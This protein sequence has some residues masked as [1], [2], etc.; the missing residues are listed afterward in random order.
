MPV[1]AGSWE[2]LH[3]LHDAC[4]SAR[5]QTIDTYQSVN[6]LLHQHNLF[7]YYQWSRQPHTHHAHTEHTTRKTQNTPHHTT[8]HHTTHRAHHTNRMFSIK[9]R[10]KSSPSSSY[11]IFFAPASLIA[12]VAPSILI[13]STFIFFA[14]SVFAAANALD[15]SSESSPIFLLFVYERKNIKKYEKTF[16]T[17]KNMENH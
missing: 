13:F 12:F 9:Q 15:S 11:R 16:K 10:W 3:S 6:I 17:W 5:F 14:F 2:S 1:F 4:Y 8:P 7:L